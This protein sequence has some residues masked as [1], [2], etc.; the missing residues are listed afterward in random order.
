MRECS[1][2]YTCKLEDD[3]EIKEVAQNLQDAESDIIS[4]TNSVNTVGFAL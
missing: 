4:V 1:A 2:D 3:E